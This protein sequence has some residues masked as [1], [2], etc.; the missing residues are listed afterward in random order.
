M[1]TFAARSR[2]PDARMAKMATAQLMAG[3]RAGKGV[4]AVSTLQLVRARL[5][6]VQNAQAFYL[7][8]RQSV[9][10]LQHRFREQD[11]DRG[12]GTLH[13]ARLVRAKQRGYLPQNNYV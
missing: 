11:V 4:P 6:A 9:N 5:R 12:D 3:S 8:A 2:M 1:A 10:W 13:M 7:R